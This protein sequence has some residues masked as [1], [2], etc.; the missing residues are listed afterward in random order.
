MNDPAPD[1]IVAPEGVVVQS[2]RRAMD[3]H[4]LLSGTRSVFFWIFGM[5]LDETHKPS[6]C[7]IM[8]ALW[9]WMGSQMIYHELSG[10]TPISNVAWNAWWVAEG[11]LAIA[12]WGPRVAAYF[13]NGGQIA[14]QTL[15]TAMHDVLTKYEKDGA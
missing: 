2:G 8:L 12:V 4:V 14:A 3:W 11:L 1:A 10:H 7:R 6:M 5:F 13:G 15:S 9:T